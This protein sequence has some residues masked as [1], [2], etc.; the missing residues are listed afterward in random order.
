MIALDR[1]DIA[2]AAARERLAPFGDRVSFVKTPFGDVSRA[3][4]TIGLTQIDGLCADLG[5]SSPQLVCGS[6]CSGK[7]RECLE[8]E[9]KLFRGRA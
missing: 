8:P 7:D 9:A 3:L 6:S 2:L 1:D 4:E 5:G